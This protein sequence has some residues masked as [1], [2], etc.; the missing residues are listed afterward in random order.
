MK[1]K[2]NIVE[3]VCQ[4]LKFKRCCGYQLEV[5]GKELMLFARYVNLCGHKGPPTT[6]LAVRWAKLP[7]DADPLYWAIRY[8][9]VRRFSQYRIL[10]DPETEI[11][12]KGLLGHQSDAYPLIFTQIKK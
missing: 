5:Q 9:T 2:Q 3:Q 7:K 6:E 12:P 11:L 10:F 8:N 1:S 4:Y